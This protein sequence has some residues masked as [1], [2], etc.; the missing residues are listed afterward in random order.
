MILFLCCYVVSHSHV[1][2]TLHV[3]ARRTIWFLASSIKYSPRPI[4]QVPVHVML[5]SVLEYESPNIQIDLA[6]NP[7]F[8]E[9][10]EGALQSLPVSQ[11]NLSL[12]N[13]VAAAVFSLRK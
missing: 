2:Y 1:A 12:G 11:E 5:R 13:C 10:I 7:K 8:L 6:S 9:Q 3:H 4:L